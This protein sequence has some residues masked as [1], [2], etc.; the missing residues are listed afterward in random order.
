MFLSGKFNPIERL[1][2][3]FCSAG[4]ADGRGFWFNFPEIFP[5]AFRPGK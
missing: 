5:D 2:H 1:F 4:T 3:G